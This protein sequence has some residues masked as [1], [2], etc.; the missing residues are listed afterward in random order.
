MTPPRIHSPSRA[1]ASL[2]VAGLLGGSGCREA[3]Q[4]LGHFAFR[5][6]PAATLPAAAN[7]DGHDGHDG[8]A[9]AGLARSVL[10]TP[11]ARRNIG[12]ETKALVTATAWKVIELPGVVVDRPGVSDRGVTAPIAGTIVKVQ[13]FPGTTVAPEAALF[14]IRLVSDSVHKSQLELFK[15]TKEIEIAQ[16]QRRRLDELALAGAVPQARL[17]EIENQ[18]DRMQATVEAYRQDLVARGLSIASIDAAAAGEFVTEIVVRA[19]ADQS[20]A[21]ATAHAAGAGAENVPFAFEV[22]SLDVE[23]GQHVEAGTVLMHL[24]DHRTLLIEGRGF[25]DDMPMVQEAARQGLG[26]EIDADEPDAST[27]PAFPGTLPIDHI[28]NTVDPATRTFAFFLALANQWHTYPQQDETRVLWRFRPGSRLRLRVAADRMDDVFVVPRDAVVREGPRAFVFRQSRDFVLRSQ[29]A[30]FERTEV[31]IVHE[32]RLTSVLANDGSLRS[33]SRIAQSGAAAIDRIW[34]SQRG[35]S[36]PSDVH[37]HADGSLHERHTPDGQAAG[38]PTPH[39]PDARQQQ[40]AS[41]RP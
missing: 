22:H 11:Q 12:L 34:K 8:N 23:L 31:H 18:L 2:V 37:V 15:A 10:L 27:W 26:I 39:A 21:D 33:G 1:I 17:Y 36:K 24:A 25:K 4:W 40:K 14:T 35:E 5:A 19:P 20:L 3:S 32:D 28:S 29:D 6:Q 16:R 38:D 13:A 9:P 41:D 7:S 30:L